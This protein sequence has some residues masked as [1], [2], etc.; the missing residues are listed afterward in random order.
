MLNILVVEDHALFREAL[1]GVVQSLGAT[2]VFEARDYA[3]ACARLAQ[4]RAMDLLLLDLH[5]PDRGGLGIVHELR[6]LHPAVPMVVISADEDPQSMRKALDAG[7]MGYIPK[8]AS[9]EV[10]LRALALVLAG[11]IFV[12]RHALDATPA[13]SPAPVT[14]RSQ[15]SPRLWGIACLLAEGCPNR[16]I[17]R[18][19]DIAEATVKAHV[20]RVFQVLGVENRAQA[21]LAA[22]ALLA[23]NDD[24]SP[25]S[26]QQALGGAS[27]KA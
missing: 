19:L 5:L 23:L 21:A 9:R 7:V 11:E 16:E 13:S 10:I 18:R 26:A 8:S 20:T 6:R 25:A 2:E 27:R 17:A 3:Q 22:Q 12:P 15:L 1:R 24:E 4:E 14:P